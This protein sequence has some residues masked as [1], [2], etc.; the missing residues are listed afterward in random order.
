MQLEREV[1]NF[2]GL[3]LMVGWGLKDPVFHKGYY[4]GWRARFPDGEF[5]PF[6]DTGH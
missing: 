6:A 2:R 1:M 5:H 3:P 4:A